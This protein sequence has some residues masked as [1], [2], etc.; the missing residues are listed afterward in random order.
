MFAMLRSLHRFAVV[1]PGR[2]PL[3]TAGKGATR[4]ALVATTLATSLAAAVGGTAAMVDAPRRPA[5]PVAAG[6]APDLAWSSVDAGGGTSTA[7][8]AGGDWSLAAAI[9]QSDAG[10]MAGGDFVLE[11][12]FFAGGAASTPPCTGDVDASGE[13]GFDDLLAVLT[14]WGACGGCPSDLDGDGVVGFDDLLAVLVGWG[15]CA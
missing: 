6:A 1:R 15:P 11:G 13:V 8:T 7:A 10:A 14:D 9:G 4:V 12:G 5:G 3:G 2:P